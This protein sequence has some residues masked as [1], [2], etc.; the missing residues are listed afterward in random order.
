[1][2]F[3]EYRK[4][5]FKQAAEVKKRGFMIEHV[6]LSESTFKDIYKVMNDYIVEF[7]LPSPHHKD[8]NIY[9][10]GFQIV[11]VKPDNIL[12]VTPL[13]PK[14]EPNDKL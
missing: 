9:L 5:V 2:T 11:L 4:E 7:N 6:L 1:M 3:A 12:K 10:D 14:Q 13:L 8:G